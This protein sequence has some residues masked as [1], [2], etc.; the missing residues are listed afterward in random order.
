MGRELCRIE[1]FGLYKGRM[2][3]FVAQSEEAVGEKVLQAKIRWR[4]AGSWI[5]V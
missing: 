3:K 5:A 1:G 4:T 2:R